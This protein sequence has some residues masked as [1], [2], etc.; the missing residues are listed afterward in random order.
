MNQSKT[1]YLGSWTSL[2]LVVGLML[3]GCSSDSNSQENSAGSGGSGGVA[4]GSAVGGSSGG[5]SAG[6]ASLGGA[7]SGGTSSGGTGVGGA[8][9]GGASSGGA[10]SGGASSGGARSG[11]SGMGGGRQTGGTGTG[12][13]AAGGR[14]AGGAQNG[15]ASTGGAAAGGEDAGGS[16]GSGGQDIVPSSGCDKTPTLSNGTITMGS[17]NYIINI[18]SGYD[19]SHPYRLILGFHGANGQ[20]SDISGDYFGLLPLSQG[21][22]I[23]IAANAVDGLWSADTDVTYVDDIL[24]QVTA[25]LCIDTTRIML[26][27]FS[28]GAAMAWTITCSRPGVFRA[29]VGHSGGGIANP[30]DCEP[31]AYLGSLGLGES[32]N[33]QA[34][35]TDQFAQWNGCTIEDLPTAPSGGHVCTNYSGCP[36]EDPV[37]WCSYDGGHT[38]SPTDAGQGSSWMP[39][40]VWTFLTQF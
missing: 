17:R 32:G 25:D 4:G 7:S 27:G 9:I 40:E 22:T 38:P 31:V 29:V 39:E 30:T 1:A 5:T 21:S 28:Q 18:P 15:G 36:D 11:G 8:S 14:S 34:T 3:S 24:E 26:E 23:F 35:Q 10:S 2:A 33:S 6:G 13:A 37:R 16:A 20:A 12:G 19:N